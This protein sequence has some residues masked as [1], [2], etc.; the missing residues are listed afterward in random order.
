MHPSLPAP[1]QT[2]LHRAIVDAVIASTPED[3]THMTLTI[4]RQAHSREVGR[5]IHE[6]HSNEGYA[7]IIPSA[8]LLDATYRLDELLQSY[9]AVFTR[10]VYEVRFKDGKGKFKSTFEYTPD[11]RIRGYVPPQEGE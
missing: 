2:P 4:T 11:S 7:P 6:L 10:A 3:W 1:E 5:L 9:G 8:E